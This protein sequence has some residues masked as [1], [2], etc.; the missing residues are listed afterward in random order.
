MERSQGARYS[1]KRW[2]PILLMG[3][4]VGVFLLNNL[5]YPAP[6]ER[7]HARRE[8]MDT[9]VFIT[10]FDSDETHAQTAIDAA[11]SRM[12]AIVAIASSFD[13]SAEVARLNATGRLD[14]PSPELMDIIEKALELFTISHGTFDITI[15]PLLNLWRYDPVAETQ[16]WDLP[17]DA[18]EQAIAAT[19]F[20]I[21]ADRLVLKYEPHAEIELVPGM[22]ITLGG[23]A[24]GYAVDQG[25]LILKE[26]GIQHALIDAGGD[27][28]VAGG[29][30][31]GGP[32]E[33]ALR[34][35]EDEDNVLAQF[36]L[37][38]GAIA[39]SGNYLRYFD[40]EAQVGHIMDPR[41]GYSAHLSSS[42]TVIAQTCTEADAFA[43]AVFVL[44][45]IAGIEII[46]R[47]EGIEAMVLAY[48]D[49][50][51]VARSRNLGNFETQKKDGV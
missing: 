45:P 20:V 49:P 46:N 25:L 28:A 8:M 31:S 30:P 1:W 21:G 17:S 41:T 51:L 13:P 48:D 19:M 6:L 32:W 2:W 11:F 3:L 33:I 47:L 15:E 24:K 29:K 35:P 22:K 4:L 18:Q 38:D 10:V 26:Q 40:P 34:D 7:Y 5:L 42:A 23:I 50:L 44:G 37:I 12:E 27:I 39:T 9:W 43:T 36:E 16:F 14:S